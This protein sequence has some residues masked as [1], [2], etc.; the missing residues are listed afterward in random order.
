MSEATSSTAKCTT[1]SR[2]G[3]VKT[4]LI[5]NINGKGRVSLQGIVYTYVNLWSDQTTWGGEFAPVDGDL[6]Y[7]PAG[8]NLLVDIDKSPV[9]K[10]V[11]VEGSLI[12]APETDPDHERFFDAYYIFIRNG[13]MEVGTKKYP[14]TSKITFTMHGNVS[15]PFLPIYGNKVIG[16][17]HGILDMHGIERNPTWTVMEATATKG[18]SKITLSRAVDWKVGEQIG[19][20]PTSY[21]P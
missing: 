7:L 16:V 20:A 4:S 6:V 5:F 19:I 15:D 8:L 11:L 2:P 13:S 10:A 1:G 3:L 18:E 14:Y 21:G 12:F 17:R 9:L